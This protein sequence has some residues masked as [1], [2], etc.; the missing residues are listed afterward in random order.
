MGHP[1]ILFIVLILAEVVILDGM[2]QDIAHHNRH[3]RNVGAVQ[4]VQIMKNIAHDEKSRYGSR[5]PPL[6]SGENF[7]H[8]GYSYIIELLL[9]FRGGR[10]SGHRI[11]NLNSAA[12]YSFFSIQ[13]TAAF[14]SFLAD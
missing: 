4:P 5:V 8:G 9:L 7:I 6:K 10:Q 2:T 14:I 11:H 12:N 13:A 3:E 1:H